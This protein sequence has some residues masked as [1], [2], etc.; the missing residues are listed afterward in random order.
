MSSEILVTLSIALI[1]A[2]AAGV[3]LDRMVERA[4][5]VWRLEGLAEAVAGILAG[6]LAL[7]V[8]FPLIAA[9]L[10]DRASDPPLARSLYILTGL[11][12]AQVAAYAPI[13]RGVLRRYGDL[14]ERWLEYVRNQKG[15]GDE[16]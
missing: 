7:A 4:V 10:A 5:E 13:A 2:A 14:R 11:A 1:G 3:I 9:L 6:P 15:V 16:A 8:S 12:A